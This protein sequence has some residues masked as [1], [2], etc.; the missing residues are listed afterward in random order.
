MT[1][2]IQSAVV[3]E[4]MG[5]RWDLTLPIA[6]VSASSTSRGSWERTPLLVWGQERTEDTATGYVCLE[7]IQ[8]V[9][10]PVAASR[11]AAIALLDAWLAD[12]S[13]YD[14]R[15]WPVLKSAIERNRLS[16]RRRFRD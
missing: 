13:G 15:V 12:D 3:F 8:S 9:V 1:V 7:R 2:G 4:P 10:R 14:E 6:D 5:L 11:R 16:E